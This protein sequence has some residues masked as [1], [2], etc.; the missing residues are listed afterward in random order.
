MSKTPFIR[1]TIHSF[2]VEA[3]KTLE[4]LSDEI[5]VSVRTLIRW[6]RG[7]PRMPV[8]YLS[9]AAEVYGKPVSEIRPD[10]AM[11]F[12]EAAQ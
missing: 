11:H 12:S 8:K 10:L 1:E 2:R 9:R 5:G 4:K 7:D 3:N 6:E